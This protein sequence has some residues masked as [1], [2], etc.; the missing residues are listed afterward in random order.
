[1]TETVQPAFSESDERRALRQAVAKL[2]GGY[3]R[4]YFVQQARSGGK[5]T[6]L[7]LE[8]G[9]HGYLGIKIAEEYGGGGGGIGGVAAVCEEVGG[10]GCSVRVVVGAAGICGTGM[11]GCGSG[12]E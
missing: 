9:R 4:D 8:I 5:T 2:A 11:R 12:G 10:Q 1:M 7:W 3:G 6:D